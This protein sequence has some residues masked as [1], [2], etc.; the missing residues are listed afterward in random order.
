MVYG[1]STRGR[2]VCVTRHIIFDALAKELQL[3]HDVC[4]LSRV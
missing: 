1:A 4:H 3:S 2:E